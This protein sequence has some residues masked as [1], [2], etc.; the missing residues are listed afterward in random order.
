MNIAA[1][2]KNL[3]RRHH[4]RRNDKCPCCTINVETAE[5]VLL[6]PE[7]GRA[8]AYRLCTRVLERWLDESDTNPDLSDS[9]VEY[10]QGRGDGHDGR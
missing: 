8:E 6:C 7:V 10:M 2:N 5:H 1:T 3:S 4:D 9:I